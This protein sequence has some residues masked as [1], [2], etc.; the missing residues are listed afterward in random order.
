MKENLNRFYKYCISRN[1]SDR[2]LTIALIIFMILIIIIAM[3]LEVHA[4]DI[5][6]S[7]VTLD[8]PVAQGWIEGIGYVYATGDDGGTPDQFW[9]LYQSGDLAHRCVHVRPLTGETHKQLLTK[10]ITNVQ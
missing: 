7:D 10:E 5:H 2:L 4:H 3:A 6:F 1:G 9:L 8:K